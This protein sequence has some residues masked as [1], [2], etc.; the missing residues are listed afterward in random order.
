MCLLQLL[1]SLSVNPTG[2][3][4]INEE[5]EI[6]SQGVMQLVDYGIGGVRD[7]EPSSKIYPSKEQVDQ[8]NQELFEKDLKNLQ[9]CEEMQ[10]IRQM[11]RQWEREIEAEESDFSQYDSEQDK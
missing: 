6:Q 4:L 8:M 9:D 5:V 3:K 1:L 7:S 2:A 10:R 11:K